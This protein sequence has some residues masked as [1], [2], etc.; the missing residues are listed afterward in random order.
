M[1]LCAG[2][3]TLLCAGG[4][5]GCRF[6]M[7]NSRFLVGKIG[8]DEPEHGQAAEIAATVNQVMKDNEI[9]LQKLAAFCKAPIEKVNRL[10]LSSSFCSNI[11]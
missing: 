5:P 8:L 6:A 2:V 3:G 7:P 10:S 1:G 11:V 9:L 4:T